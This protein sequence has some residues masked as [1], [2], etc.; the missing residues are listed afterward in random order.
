MQREAW[1]YVTMLSDI[2]EH[3]DLLKLCQTSRVIRVSEKGIRC[4]LPEVLITIDAV[5]FLNALDET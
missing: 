4:T 3:H 5:K 2:L 1:A